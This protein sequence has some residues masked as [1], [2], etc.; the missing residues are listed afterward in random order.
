MALTYANVSIPGP[1]FDDARR[2]VDTHPELGFRS[3]SELATEALRNRLIELRRIVSTNTAA[4]AAAGHAPTTKA[5]DAA[6]RGTGVR[7]L[8]Q[9]QHKTQR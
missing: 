8:D 6:R 1:L 5:A 7:A 9:G 4:A 3:A 2:F